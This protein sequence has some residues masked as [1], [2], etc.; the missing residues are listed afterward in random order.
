MKNKS[1]IAIVGALALALA[2]V[3]VTGF[4]YQ[5]E[6]DRELAFLPPGQGEGILKGFEGARVGDF[7]SKDGQTFVLADLKSGAFVFKGPGP[8]S[9]RDK[10]TLW[11]GRDPLSVLRFAKG[12]DVAFVGRDHAGWQETTSWFWI[13]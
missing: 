5:A 2:T 9:S 11:V 6:V 4:G 13:Q 3:I 10:R 7:L 1:F 8:D 12:A